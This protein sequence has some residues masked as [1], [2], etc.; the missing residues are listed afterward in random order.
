MPSSPNRT[1]HIVAVAVTVPGLDLLSYR[2][3]AAAAPAKGARVNVPLGSRTVTGVVV[4]PAAEA[5]AGAQLRDVTAVLDDGAFL[6]PAIV[7]LA[8]WVGDYYSSGPGDALAV[9]LPPSARRGEASAFRTRKVV[10]AAVGADLA[11]A[12]ARLRGVKQRAALAHDG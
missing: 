12:E 9:A 6:P 3:I 10:R 2:V 8:V 5:P 4:N 7:D 1:E 11:A